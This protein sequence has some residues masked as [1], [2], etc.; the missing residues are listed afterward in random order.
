MKVINCQRCPFTRVV[1]PAYRPTH[2]PS[3]FRTVRSQTINVNAGGS[4]DFVD[5]REFPLH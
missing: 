1:Y 4:D 2:S 5:P 3:R